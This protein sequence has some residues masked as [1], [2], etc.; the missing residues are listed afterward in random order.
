MRLITNILPTHVAEHFLHRQQTRKTLL[1][2]QLGA[3]LGDVPD[4]YHQE[5]ACVAIM[6][7]SI[8]NFS[9]E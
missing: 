4:L 1:G 9:G 6:F 3:S 8:S 7:A 5:F 2:A